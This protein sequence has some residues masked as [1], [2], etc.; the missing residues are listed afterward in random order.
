MIPGLLPHMIQLLCACMLRAC[1][2][3]AVFPGVVWLMVWKARL[4]QVLCEHGCMFCSGFRSCQAS[5]MLQLQ[6][7]STNGYLCSWP[8]CMHSVCM[9]NAIVLGSK[10]GRCCLYKASRFLHS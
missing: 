3:C 2:M 10:D 8:M 7:V 5:L 4:E 9:M 6:L 1:G